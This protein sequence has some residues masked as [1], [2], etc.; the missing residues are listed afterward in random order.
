MGLGNEVFAVSRRA[1]TGADWVMS[2]G[3]GR[4]KPFEMTVSVIHFSVWTADFT[5]SVTDITDSVTDLTFSSPTFAGPS[6]TL[7]SG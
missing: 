4:S 1:K 6:Q 7:P 5:V 2:L 3:N